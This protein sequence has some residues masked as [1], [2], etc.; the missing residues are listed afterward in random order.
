MD[1]DILISG[2]IKT[3]HYNANKGIPIAIGIITI[4]ELI[5]IAI[6]YFLMNDSSYKWVLYVVCIPFLLAMLLWPFLVKIV[7]NQIKNTISFRLRSVIPFVW[8]CK[9]STFQLNEIDFFKLE[10]NHF[11]GKRYYKI[12]AKLKNSPNDVCVISGQDQSCSLEFSDEMQ[13]FTDKLNALIRR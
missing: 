4:T 13:K 7:L 5:N 11:L 8:N 3:I 9:D 1:N 2:P 6:G 10:L 12:F